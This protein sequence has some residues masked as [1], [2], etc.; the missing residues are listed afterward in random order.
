MIVKP[1]ER[2]IALVQ[3]Y[4]RESALLAQNLSWPQAKECAQITVDEIL[5]ATQ[6]LTADLY[7]ELDTVNFWQGIKREIEKL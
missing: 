6:P 3:K 1:R 5:A 4:Y 7:P 2:A